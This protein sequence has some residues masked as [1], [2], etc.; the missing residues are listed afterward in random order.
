MLV[1]SRRPE[2]FQLALFFAAYVLGCGFAQTL[3]IIPIQTEVR[4]RGQGIEFP[5]KIFEPFFTTKEHS[6]GMGLPVCRSIIKSHNGRLRAERNEPYG[7]TF[8]FTLPAEA[9]AAA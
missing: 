6:M 2:L 8:I 3:A 5:E 9:K 1:W 4:D 7:A